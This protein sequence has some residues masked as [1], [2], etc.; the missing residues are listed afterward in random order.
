M[1]I[2]TKWL[3]VNKK[4][5]EQQSVKKDTLKK[6][7]EFDIL[8][9]A[10][11]Q[12]DIFKR[13]INTLWL[14]E[15]IQCQAEKLFYWHDNDITKLKWIKYL[16]KLIDTINEKK[17]DLESLKGIVNH[18]MHEKLHEDMWIE[19]YL[20][21]WSIIVAVVFVIWIAWEDF[22]ELV[23]LALFSTAIVW[24]INDVIYFSESKSEY[25]K[26]K[27]F[28]MIYNLFPQINKKEFN[29]M[30]ELYDD[31]K[32]NMSRFVQMMDEYEKDGKIT[33]EE[34]KKIDEFISKPSM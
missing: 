26:N 28:D 31:G 3:E 5:L 29:K 22:S 24:G 4:E 14:P 33:P 9:Q 21:L 16:N 20:V 17:N 13:K 6:L 18:S 27:T 25:D 1:W 10:T 2:E 7:S 34:R 19:D 23:W 32:L 15:S 8:K 30:Y 12:F 11:K